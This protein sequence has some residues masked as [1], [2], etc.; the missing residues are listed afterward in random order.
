[1]TTQ[2]ISTLLPSLPTSRYRA[3]PA[4]GKRTPSLAVLLPAT[5]ANTTIQLLLHQLV[6]SLTILRSAA[7]RVLVG[8]ATEQTAQALR[9]WLPPIARQ[10]EATMQRLRALPLAKRPAWIDLSQALTVLV[11]AADM[12]GQGQLSDTTD[13]DTYGLIHRSTDRAMHSLEALHR[14]LGANT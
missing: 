3:S 1:M 9:M 13:L 10:A 11:L 5:S 2:L 6:Q 14:Q 4:T 12:L 8:P 7:E